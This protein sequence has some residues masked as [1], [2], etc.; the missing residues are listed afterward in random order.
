MEE[1]RR[2]WEAAERRRIAEEKEI[3]RL[4]KLKIEEDIRIA[5]IKEQERLE[6]ERQAVIAR[7]EAARLEAIRLVEDEK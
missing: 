4:A 3:A 2:A 5:E 1:D 7:A 6:A